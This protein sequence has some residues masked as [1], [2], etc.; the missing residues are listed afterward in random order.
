[1]R[2]IQA[3]EPACR[4]AACHGSLI[5][6]RRDLVYV[7][8]AHAERMGQVAHPGEG[9][10]PYAEAKYANYFQVGHR[11][12]EFYLEF[13][14]AEDEETEPYIHTRIVS[15]PARAK[16]L[17]EVLQQNITR[18]EEEFGPIERE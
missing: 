18:Y 1:M 15:T 8:E 13:G 4:H 3:V 7:H 16:A 17:L 9:S 5:S 14:Q 6:A 10:R 12:F 11:L 2:P